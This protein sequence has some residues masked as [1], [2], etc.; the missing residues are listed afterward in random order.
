MQKLS[1]LLIFVFGVSFLSTA[2]IK[3]EPGYYIDN[4]GVKN[5]CLIKN[6]GWSNNPEKFVYRLSE[7]SEAKTKGLAEVQGFGIDNGVSFKRFIVEIDKSTQRLSDLGKTAIPEYVTDTLFLKELVTGATSLYGY[8]DGVTKS[9]FYTTPDLKVTQLI[10]KK[11]KKDGSVATN[12]QYLTQLLLDVN[13]EKEPAN[14]LQQVKYIQKDLIA[15]FIKENKC[16]NSEYYSTILSWA[17]QET[18]KGLR[19]SLRPG[20]TNA[21]SVLE[22][23]PASI[24]DSEFDFGSQINPRIGVELELSFPDTNNKWAF[25]FEPYYTSYQETTI[26]PL[27]TQANFEAEIDFRAVEFS[28]GVRYYLFLSNKSRL[29]VN[30]GALIGI[31]GSSKIS[32]E[33]V[34]EF[35]INSGLRG[36]V[37]IGYN[38]NDRLSVEVRQNTPYSLIVNEAEWRSQYRSMEFILGIRV[39]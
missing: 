22:Y 14:K 29:F 32:V 2:Q 34:A 37:G 3:F 23:L 18:D 13:C 25:I 30:I 10:Y 16:K 38:Y 36:N 21:S 11:F 17:D 27:G 33:R 6:V 1:I 7:D 12:K 28:T 8:R 5:T 15:H 4:E 31:T 9:F 20:V 24:F 35:E 39:F 19:L 26:L